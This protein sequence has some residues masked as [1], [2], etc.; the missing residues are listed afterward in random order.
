V[1][2][3]D[4]DHDFVEDFDVAPTFL[5]VGHAADV[6]DQVKSLKKEEQLDLEV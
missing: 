6:E 4:H 2:V 3:D 5:D 1:V